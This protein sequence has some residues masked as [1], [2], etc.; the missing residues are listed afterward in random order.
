MMKKKDNVASFCPGRRGKELANSYYF[1]ALVVIRGQDA[2]WYV[3]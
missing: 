1:Y 3:F 2:L